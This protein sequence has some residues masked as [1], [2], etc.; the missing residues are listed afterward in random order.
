M[1]WSR[2]KRFCTFLLVDFSKSRYNCNFFISNWRVGKKR[3]NVNIIC[4]SKTQPL[5]TT[6]Q[7]ESSTDTVLPTPITNKQQHKIKKN[8]L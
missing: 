3:K 7:S 1:L 5:L 2:K 6:E 8:S 4:G